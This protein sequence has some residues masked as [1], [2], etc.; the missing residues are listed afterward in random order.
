MR[1]RLSL[2]A[3]RNAY[4][5]RSLWSYLREILDDSGG[6]HM[7]SC[8][9]RSFLSRRFLS[10]PPPPPPGVPCLLPIAR[11]IDDRGHQF[12]QRATTIVLEMS[13][14]RRFLNLRGP[15]LSPARKN[16]VIG[17]FQFLSGFPS[18]PGDFGFFLPPQTSFRRG[19]VVPVSRPGSSNNCFS[20][21][22]HADCSRKR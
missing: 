4:F 9:N 14:G 15:A 7:S 20:F 10:I 18:L 13:E 12:H 17:F 11:D 1:F 16:V 22:A 3:S 21:S 2:L 19:F 6:P 8:V 5:S